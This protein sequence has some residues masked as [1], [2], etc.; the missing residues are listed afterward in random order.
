MTENYILVDFENVGSFDLQALKRD[1]VH[2]IVFLGSNQAKLPTE[3]A[4]RMQSLG[5]RG[6]YVQINGVGPNALDFHIAYTIGELRI[7]GEQQFFHI[8]SKDQG[9]DPLLAYLKSK[10]MRAARYETLAEIPFLTTNVPTSTADRAQLVVTYFDNAKNPRPRTTNTLKNFFRTKFGKEVPDCELQAVIQSL[11]SR[12]ILSVKD[13]K[14]T[15][16]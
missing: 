16:P 6:Q 4:V 13:E 12:K 11:M 5:H 7:A 10:K 2:V 3:L 15:Y 8:I 9:F 1:D 14:V